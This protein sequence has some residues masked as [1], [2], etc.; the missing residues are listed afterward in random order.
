MAEPERITSH[1]CRPLVTHA[2]L[3]P[4]L[5]YSVDGANQRDAVT[6]RSAWDAGVV[7]AARSFDRLHG[8]MGVTQVGVG[9]VAGLAVA[10]LDIR[11]IPVLVAVVFIAAVAAYW[12]VPTACAGIVCLLAPMK[13]RD[14]ARLALAG[15]EQKLDE[16]RAGYERALTDVRTEEREYRD[17]VNR[18]AERIRAR[19]DLCEALREGR[20]Y[21]RNGLQVGVSGIAP[22]GVLQ[23]WT[24]EVI[25]NLEVL[26][27][28]AS[29]LRAWGSPVS[30]GRLATP[31]EVSVE[32]ERRLD[33]LESMI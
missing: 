19:L 9:A 6:E 29:E 11:P 33:L 10:R 14:A 13:Q 2:A 28:D 7:A 31:A 22:E 12:A 8:P 17:G 16:Q 21:V 18:N 24:N 5:A 32:Y 27:Q 15:A 20:K 25:R 26:G 4:A 1:V 3:G 30:A 23:G